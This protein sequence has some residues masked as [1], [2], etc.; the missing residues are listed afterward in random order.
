MEHL[1][2]LLLLASVAILIPT[3]VS[4]QP[5]LSY[6][7]ALSPVINFYNYVYGRENAFWLLQVH[8]PPSGQIPQEQV[9]K[10]LSFTLK[11]T[12][13][14]VTVELPLKECDFKTDG[15]VKE[16]QASASTEQDISALVLTCGPEASAPRRFRRSRH[17]RRRRP[18]NAFNVLQTIVFFPR[19]K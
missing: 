7:K 10:F 8:A 1:G 12:V 2:K 4:P 9:Q 16:C 18:W 13:C 14:P 19:G 3:W 15:L 17:K 11:E 6:E 5:F